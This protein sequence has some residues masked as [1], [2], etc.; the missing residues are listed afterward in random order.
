MG[1]G[2]ERHGRKTSPRTRVV[3]PDHGTAPGGDGGGERHR[4]FLTVLTGDLIGRVFELEGRDTVVGRAP[5][6]GVFLDEDSVSRRHAVLRTSRAG[7]VTV[8]DLG[9]TNGTFVNGERIGRAVL[10]DGDRLLFGSSVVLKFNL[11]D[12][13]EARAQ[14]H[15]YEAAT[16][17][18]LTGLYNQRAFLAR[19]A[20]ELSFAQRHVSRLALALIDLDQF[21][22]VNDRYGHGA[23]DELLAQLAAAVSSELRD[24]DV[25]CRYGGDEL[26]VILRDT[27]A[28]A[29]AGLAERVRDAIARRTFEVHDD[30]GLPRSLRVTVSVGVAALDH[31]SHRDRRH[32]LDAADRRLLH[33]KR[34]GR[35]RVCDADP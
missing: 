34:S 2:A 28:D 8:E 17:D 22:Q 30:G 3:H 25:L 20:E 6:C 15:L 18:A 32:L 9:S 12:T 10:A 31:D 26:A 1:H 21:K 19:L 5:G 4:P 29:A 11:E 16:R 7:E 27:G 33:A 24:E 35:D 13:P 14:R 23:G